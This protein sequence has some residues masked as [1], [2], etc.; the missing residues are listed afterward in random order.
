MQFFA[1]LAHR[2]YQDPPVYFF[3]VYHRPQF[4]L[5]CLGY[6]GE[7]SDMCQCYIDFPLNE[8][9]CLLFSLATSMAYNLV[10]I[11]DPVCYW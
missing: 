7:F 2:L 8:V 5:I 4:V 1:F 11:F 3:S 9:V 6:T 10:G